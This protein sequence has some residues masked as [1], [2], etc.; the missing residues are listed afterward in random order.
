[1]LNKWDPA[2][3]VLPVAPG[4]AKQSKSKQNGLSPAVLPGVPGKAKQSKA[5]AVL[6]GAP[7][8]AKLCLALVSF[9]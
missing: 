5:R 7:G 3:A 6:P 2:R 9:A 4:K 1:M 8:K